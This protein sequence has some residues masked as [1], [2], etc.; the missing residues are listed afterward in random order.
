MAEVISDVHSIN[1]TY[2]MTIS[3]GGVFVLHF[4][5]SFIHIFFMDL[6]HVIG[7][8]NLSLLVSKDNS[9]GIAKVN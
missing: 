5:H 4:F 2:E 8:F 6:V 7:F 9:H 3:L 1:N